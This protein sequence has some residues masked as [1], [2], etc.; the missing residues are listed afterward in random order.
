[1]VDVEAAAVMGSN[2]SAEYEILIKNRLTAEN[3]VKYFQAK[4]Q[5]KVFCSFGPAG[6]K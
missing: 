5:G 1:M 2:I 6:S 4:A 3:N